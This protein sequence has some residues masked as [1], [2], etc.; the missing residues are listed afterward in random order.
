MFLETPRVREVGT[1]STLK[2]GLETEVIVQG[3]RVPRTFTE[4]TKGSMVVSRVM[5]S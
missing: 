3:I 4:T 5:V 1:H 2:L